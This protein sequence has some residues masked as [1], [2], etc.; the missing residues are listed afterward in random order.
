[1]VDSPYLAEPGKKFKISDRKSDDTGHFKD[2]RDAEKDIDENLKKLIALQDKLYATASHSV[3]IVL[4]AMDGGGKDGAIDHVFSGVN[5]QGCNVTSFKQPSHEELAHDYLWRIHAAAPK[6]GMIE[7]FNRSHYESVL[8]ERV[9]KLVPEHVWSKRYDHINH[10]EK[11]LADEGTV[12]LKFF[13]NI[14]WEE[15]KVRMEKRLADPKKNWKFDPE[16]LKNRERWDD[17]MAAY[18]DAVRKC[19]TRHAPWYVVP[20]DHKWFR[21]WLISD[22]LVRTLDKLDLKYPP[23]LKDAEDIKVK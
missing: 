23:P 2:K 1:M 20:A 7:I 4:Q 8:V 13:L 12:I 3:L 22:T 18:E 14:S 10:F 16:D 21:N 19:S 15:Q 11:L 5:P 9:K 17:Y 6:K